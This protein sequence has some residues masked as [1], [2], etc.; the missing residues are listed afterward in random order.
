MVLTDCTANV[1]IFSNDILRRRGAVIRK[2]YFR[3]FLPIKA[4]YFHSFIR[5]FVCSLVRS[6][7]RLFIHL[8]IHSFIHSLLQVIM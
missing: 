1:D 8:L 5:M 6:S 2:K 4:S 7:I 3:R